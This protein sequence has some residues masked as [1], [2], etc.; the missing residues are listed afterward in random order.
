[1]ADAFASVR[2]TASEAASTGKADHSV[3]LRELDRRQKLVLNLFSESKYV[4][5]REIAELLDIHPRTALNLC[6]KW[7]GS[8]FLIQFGDANKSRKYALHAQWLELI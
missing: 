8:E 6:K 4:T 5:T 2:Q 7:V 1:M 3:L